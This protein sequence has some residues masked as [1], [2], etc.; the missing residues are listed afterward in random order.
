MSALLHRPDPS[1]ELIG[2]VTRMAGVSREEERQDK[3][4]GFVAREREHR[5]S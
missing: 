2:R 5:L 1:L 4:D 3:S